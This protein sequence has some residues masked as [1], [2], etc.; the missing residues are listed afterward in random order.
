MN[1]SFFLFIENEARK[2]TERMSKQDQ[3]IY[4]F[5][6]DRFNAGGDFN[7]DLSSR[8]NQDQV[9]VDSFF[10]SLNDIPPSPILPN[11]TIASD[12]GKTI[13]NN[14]FYHEDDVS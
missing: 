12:F 11:Q 1:I 14:D 3:T 7:F 8:P 5:K 9:V 6:D 13:I 4:S 2:K 10:P